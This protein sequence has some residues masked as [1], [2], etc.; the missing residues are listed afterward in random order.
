MAD[1][2]LKAA[3]E[4]VKK[5]LPAAGEPIEYEFPTGEKIKAKDWKEAFEIAAKMTENTKTAHREEKALREAAEARAQQAQPAKQPENGDKTF[6]A[7]VYWSMV[8]ASSTDPMKLIEAQNYMDSF[9]FGIPQDQ[10]VS[11]FAETVRK[12]DAL[13]DQVEIER[14]KM[15][16]LDYPGDEKSA[17]ILSETL[18][19]MGI[20]WNAR[21]LGMVYNDLVKQGKI[22][23]LETEEKTE[24]KTTFRGPAPSLSGGASGHGQTE[25]EM[26]ESLTTPQLEALLIKQGMLRR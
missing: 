22:T 7:T 4:E 5:E 18:K 20:E 24:E 26:A 16:H 13:Y 19:E 23:P 15:Q 12:T 21:T 11:T 1:D 2:S 10:V 3:I 25:E 9:R 6:D 8:N 17:G 14:F